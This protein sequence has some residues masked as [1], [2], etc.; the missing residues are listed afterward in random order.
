M[1]PADDDDLLSVVRLM[2]FC[3]L[4]ALLLGLLLVLLLSRLLLLLL[5]VLS[6]FG[7]MPSPVAGR[8]RFMILLCDRRRM[9]LFHSTC[10]PL[11]RTG[12]HHQ[13]RREKLVKTLT[14]QGQ[15]A[16]CK[17]VRT[18]CFLLFEVRPPSE[19]A[20]APRPSTSTSTSTSTSRV[21]CSTAA[22][23]SR[24]SIEKSRLMLC[25]SPVQALLLFDQRQ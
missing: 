14:R 2:I 7:F 15:I 11:C 16:I 24:N 22:I 5:Q 23:R 3:C 10:D 21:E 19:A 4:S 12:L 8:S 25:C 13:K 18:F 17:F 9:H 6:S 1:V 20:A